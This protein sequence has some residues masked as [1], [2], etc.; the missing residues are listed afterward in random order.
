[1]FTQ[2]FDKYMDALSGA[3][4]ARALYY[5][6]GWQGGTVHQL[7][8]VTGLTVDQILYAPYEGKGEGLGSSHTG[9]FCA[10]RTCSKDWRVQKL[11][12]EHRGDV[13]YWHG[14]MTGFYATGALDGK[15]TEQ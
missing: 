8:D 4:R 6:F 13:A 15:G 7:A 14:V 12:D 11:A 5:Y 2:Q 3:D 9:G 1:M 10:V